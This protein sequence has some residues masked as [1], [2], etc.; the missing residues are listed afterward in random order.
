MQTGPIFEQDVH[1]VM[2]FGSSKNPS[3]IDSCE[4]S[5][6][7]EKIN[8]NNIKEDNSNIVEI[9]NSFLKSPLMIQLAEN[10]KNEENYSGFSDSK[11]NGCSRITKKISFHL[12]NI[13]K[14]DNYRSNSN[15]NLLQDI[16]NREVDTSSS[17][18][19]MLMPNEE[20]KGF[21]QKEFLMQTLENSNK[22][23]RN[24]EVGKIKKNKENNVFLNGK[25][26]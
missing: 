23:R 17:T 19:S 22:Y 5:I 3:P 13:E 10:Q 2:T 20:L 4:N 1:D 11:G 26:C 15:S 6:K 16:T 14:K 24:S 8:H 7:Y 18:F 9:A 21:F 12:N 25:L